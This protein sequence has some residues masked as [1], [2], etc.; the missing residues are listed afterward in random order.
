MPDLEAAL[1]Q[2]RALRRSLEDR[3]WAEVKRLRAKGNRNKARCHFEN[4]DRLEALLQEGG[5]G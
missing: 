3:L 1:Q 5:D 2:E 4:A